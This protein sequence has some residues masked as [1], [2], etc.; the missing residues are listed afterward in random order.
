MEWHRGCRRLERGHDLRGVGD[1]AA[2][3]RQGRVEDAVVADPH[4]WR[5]PAQALDRGDFH[6]ES[7]RRVFRLFGAQIRLAA[8][9]GRVNRVYG[10]APEGIDIRGG[11]GGGAVARGG[12]RLV[13]AGSGP[14]LLASMV[15]YGALYLAPGSPIAFLTRGRTTSPEEIEA[16]CRTIGEALDA[17]AVGCS[18]NRNMLKDAFVP[19]TKAS[20]A[21][22][23]ALSRAVGARDSILQTS[24]ASF[25]G[26]EEWSPWPREID[27][28][29]EMSLAGNLRITFPV[30][31][32]H[33]DPARW[34]GVVRI[35]W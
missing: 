14:L 2:A 1:A 6:H 4:P 29:R 26:K 28:L 35:F 23:L 12:Q 15:V 33:Q 32:D 8:A 16:I 22:L 30:V 34:R 18:A 19:G 7:G 13:V 25:Y 21:E 9:G 11:S 10:V 27:L 3:E 31:E 17:G 5:D 24:P 20:D